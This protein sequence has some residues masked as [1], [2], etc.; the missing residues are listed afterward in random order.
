MMTIEEQVAKLRKEAE[1]KTQEAE[2]LVK[3]QELYPDLQRHVTRWKTERYYS[4]AV[5]GEVTRFDLRHSCGC[6][7]D[8][9][10]ELWPY[11]ETEHGKVYSDPPRFQVGEKH[12]MGGDRPYDGWKKKLEAA[13]FPEIIVGAVGIHFDNDR[14]S[15]IE[16]AEDS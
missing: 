14:I 5:N 10:L 15:R 8:S 11:L 7:N 6:C 3:L 12:W 1:E 13:G 4:K 9:P 2:R 16:I